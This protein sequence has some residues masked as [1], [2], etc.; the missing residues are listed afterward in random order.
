MIPLLLY[1]PSLLHVG[2]LDVKS[3]TGITMVQVFV[4][5]LSGMLAHRR[6]H[7]VH[8]ALVLTGGV[9]MA[10]GS[11]VGSLASKHVSAGFLLLLFALMATVAAGLV[12]VRM[13]SLEL[14]IFA[15]RLRFSR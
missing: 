5:A 9:S 3:V 1:A 11:L 10:A 4:A 12:L 2:R 13:E 6:V 14:P 15:E 8:G 7:A